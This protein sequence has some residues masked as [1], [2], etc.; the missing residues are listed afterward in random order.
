MWSSTYVFYKHLLNAPTASCFLIIMADVW[1]AITINL[2]LVTDVFKNN[3]QNRNIAEEQLWV[4]AF[5][6]YYT[7][8]D[9][10]FGFLLECCYLLLK[11]RPQI[12]EKFAHVK[13]TV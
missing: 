1:S 3:F 8:S 2:N 13:V 10:S 7:Q 9:L 12:S 6:L 11:F 5:V 4:S